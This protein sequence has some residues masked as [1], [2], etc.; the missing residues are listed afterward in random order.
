VILKT[1]HHQSMHHHL[2]LNQVPQEGMS[3]VGNLCESSGSHRQ[4]REGK[5]SELSCLRREDVFSVT[6]FITGELLPLVFVAFICFLQV[7]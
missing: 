7:K 4:S 6:S 3:K 5:C 2:N 1:C